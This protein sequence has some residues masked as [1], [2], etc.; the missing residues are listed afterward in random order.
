MRSV[1]VTLTVL[2]L[3]A[4]LASPA[5]ADMLLLEDGRIYDGMKVTKKP[6][7]VVVHFE[8]GDVFVKKEMVREVVIEGKTDFV[9]RTEKEKEQFEKGLVPFEGRWISPSQRER[10]VQKR[11]EEKREEMKKLKELGE[12]RNRH[13]ETTKHFNFGST[14]QPH[15]FE[16]FR[17]MMEA[18]YK[19][20]SKTWK[21][22]QPRE[23]GRLSV[24][25]YANRKKF[26]RNSGAGGGVLGY[27]KFVEPLELHFFYDRLDPELTVGVLFHETNHYL[28]MLIDPKFVMPHF[29]GEALAEYYGAATWDEKK[30][31]LT[32]GLVQE[33][34]LAEVQLDIKRGELMP[35]EKMVKNPRMYEHYTWG[36]TL[37]HFLMNDRKLEKKFR[38]WVISLAK[39]RGVKRVP[40]GNAGLVTVEGDEVWRTFREA[41]DLD[42]AEDVKDL[43]KRWHDYVME[44]LK[45]ESARGLDVAAMKAYSSGWEV[46]SRRLFREAI[47][48][49]STNPVTYWRYGIALRRKE[50]YDEA[51]KHFRKAI[52]LDPLAASFYADLALTLEQEGDEAEAVR[53]AKLAMEVSSDDPQIEYK[54][55][56]LLRGR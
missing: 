55:Y 29:P 45:V 36:W 51:L 35:L 11:I 49:G 52:E 31:K 28:Q 27:F 16:R 9:P 38:R 50:K 19:D 4:I 37:A 8:H 33:G 12:W 10:E 15:I 22:S 14:V 7:G 18:Y 43:E 26:L 46:R 23:L 53:N 3:L 47:E 17:D 41:L 39:G 20:F 25:F 32:V 6:E 34:R 24:A 5:Y 1:S 2:L 54:V 21:V 48:A 13:E 40:Q 42:D 44:E 56:D 30:G